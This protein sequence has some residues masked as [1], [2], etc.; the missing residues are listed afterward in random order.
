MSHP[1]CRHLKE[2][3]RLLDSPALRGQN[4]CHFLPGAAR[5][6]PGPVHTPKAV[7]ASPS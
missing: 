1:T 2:D 6:W 4:F 5:K 7:A 3:W